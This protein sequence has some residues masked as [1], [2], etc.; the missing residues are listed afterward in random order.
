MLQIWFFY[1]T[2]KIKLVIVI[3]MGII[4][5]ICSSVSN[6]KPYES[7][8]GMLRNV[9]D[10]ENLKIRSSPTSY[11]YL[12]DLTNPIGAYYDRVNP[13][14]NPPEL[15]RKL[16]R[17]TQLH[18]FSYYWFRDIP[19]FNV[20]E[21]LLDGALVGIKG[22]RG[23]IDYLIGKSIVEF[24]TKDEN[25]K[26]VDEVTSHYSN[27]LEQLI[28][29]AAIH[30]SRPKQNILVFMENVKPYNFKVFRVEIKDFNKIESTIKERIKLLDESIENKNPAPLG[31]CRY[32]NFDC[33]YRVNKICNC[34]GL[35]PVDL[36]YLE[37]SIEI[38]FA[39]KF[40]EL[41][42]FARDSSEIS[43]I[44]GLTSFDIIAPRKHCMTSVLGIEDGYKGNPVTEEYKACLGNC[45]YLM[46]KK[47]D[48]NLSKDEIDELQKAH[49]DPRIRCGIRWFKISQSGKENDI[50]APAITKVSDF[51][52]D[53][54]H[55]K[56]P[57]KYSIAELGIA[58]ATYKKNTGLIFYVYPK[59]ND[60]VK[61]F[62]VSFDNPKK[63]FTMVKKQVDS[64]QSSKTKEDFLSLPKCPSYFCKHC[65][66]YD[67]CH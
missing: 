25:P 15:A 46:K 4:E 45:L 64:L 53:I 3:Y 58:C 13:T 57:S 59:V 28:F 8:S 17:G 16:I 63:I 1:I 29:Y 38:S 50:I 66:T 48:L 52:D 56:K 39:S 32:Y 11:Y 22:V 14:P 44:F 60:L 24:K 62:K 42:E 23:K 54:R 9:I 7:I 6:I 67:I 37:E 18:N 20:E 65:P 55:T 35:E 36:K 34:E 33:K 41:L 19:N 26:D 51:V 5:N 12:T 10:E 43:D 30:P 61:V 40:T 31:R 27:D 2:F 21:G 47:Y 49:R